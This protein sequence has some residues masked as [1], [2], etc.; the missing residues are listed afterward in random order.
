MI[1]VPFRGAFCQK[2][3]EM[4]NRYINCYNSEDKM[5]HEVDGKPQL[6]FTLGELC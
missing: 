2:T 1:K 6:T 4:R 5:N 3:H